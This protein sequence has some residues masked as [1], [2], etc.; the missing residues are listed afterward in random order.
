MIMASQRQAAEPNN[1]FPLIEEKTRIGKRRIR[2]GKVR[3]STPVESVQQL[4]SAK[5]EQQHVDIA[6]V[7]VNKPIKKAPSVRTIDGVIIVP[8]VEEVMVIEKRLI[9]KEELHIRR[10]ITAEHVRVP[11]SLRKQQALIE[12][13]PSDAHPTRK[14]GVKE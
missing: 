3:V 5:L 10:R 11:V 8:V 9:L 12:R 6:R 4:A 13:V 2:T 1:R 7:P 14:R